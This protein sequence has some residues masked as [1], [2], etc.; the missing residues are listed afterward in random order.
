MPFALQ[1]FVHG[2]HIG[3]SDDTVELYENGELAELVRLGREGDL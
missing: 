1:V 3:G 2:K